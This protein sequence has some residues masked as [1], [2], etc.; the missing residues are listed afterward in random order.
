VE[1]DHLNDLISTKWLDSYMLGKL[2][3]GFAIPCKHISNLLT[4]RLANQ[5][6]KTRA[7]CELHHGWVL[8]TTA[9]PWCPLSMPSFDFL[10]AY[11]GPSLALLMVY[12]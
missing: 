1:I 6:D 9:G 5:K 8:V 10:G 3:S 12:G 2:T 4:K 7:E 11:F